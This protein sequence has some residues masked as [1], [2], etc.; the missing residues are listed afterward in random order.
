MPCSEFRQCCLCHLLVKCSKP[1]LY[2]FQGHHNKE[3]HFMGG[4]G[5]Q[6]P[7][8]LH[9]NC[10]TNQLSL[11]WMHFFAHNDEIIIRTNEA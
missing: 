8:K 1:F 7:T 2:L 6:F 3:E 10:S 4:V 9:S 5:Y 11:D